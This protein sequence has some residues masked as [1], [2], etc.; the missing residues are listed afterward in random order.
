MYNSNINVKSNISSNYKL[1]NKLKSNFNINKFFSN[2]V[3]QDLIFKFDE[4]EIKIDNNKT[5]I[6][7]N[8]DKKINNIKIDDDKDDSFTKKTKLISTDNCFPFPPNDDDD[9]PDNHPFDSKINNHNCFLN[10]LNNY[11]LS[12]SSY[13]RYQ[14]TN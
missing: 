8:K 3:D 5:I 7:P 13:D 4:D 11:R 9:P 1:N 2:S 14:L 6:Y 10:L 12:P